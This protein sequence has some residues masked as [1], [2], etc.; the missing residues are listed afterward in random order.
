MIITTVLDI[1][2]LVALVFIV[3]AEY[4]TTILRINNENF[5]YIQSSSHKKSF[6]I[7]ID[8]IK[9]VRVENF[10]LMVRDQE[11]KVHFFDY[12]SKPKNIASIVNLKIIEAKKKPIVDENKKNL[13][14]DDTAPT[15]EK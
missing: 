8:D 5:I 6:S 14:F 11:G 2:C 3:I 4:Q 13:S 7:A 15:Q 1:G 9:E 10:G 12:I